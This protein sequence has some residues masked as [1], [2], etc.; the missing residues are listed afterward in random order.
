[1]FWRYGSVMTSP[2][3]YSEAEIRVVRLSKKLKIAC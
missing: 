1:M 2:S 3:K